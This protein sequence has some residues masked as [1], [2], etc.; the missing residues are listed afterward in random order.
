MSKR[1]LG[2][3]TLK[4]CARHLKNSI[5]YVPYIELL[6]CAKPENVKK[7][8]RVFCLEKEAVW[9]W[10]LNYFRAGAVFCFESKARHG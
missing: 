3:F 1:Q 2:N 6:I 5:Q 10:K 8:I 4:D 9:G 7:T